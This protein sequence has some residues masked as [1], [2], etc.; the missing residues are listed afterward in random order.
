MA[1]GGA[2]RGVAPFPGNFEVLRIKRESFLPVWRVCYDRTHTANDDYHL[3]KLKM[4]NGENHSPFFFILPALYLFFPRSPLPA[5]PQP[6]RGGCRALK[7][8]EAFNFKICFFTSFERVLNQSTGF[9]KIRQT[10]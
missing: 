5:S 7:H 1:G 9:V 10:L 2:G 8:F 6:L 4:K 3:L